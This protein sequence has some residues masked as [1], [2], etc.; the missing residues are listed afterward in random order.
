SPGALPML[1][2]VTNTRRPSGLTA[3]E[4]GASATPRA[5]L[6]RLSHSRVPG[7]A[8][9][10]AVAPA[11]PAPARPSADTA[12]PAVIAASTRPLPLLIGTSPAWIRGGFPVPAG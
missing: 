5:P 4:T 1:N 9:G 11:E 3:I 8:E 12:R 10:C 6:K 7:P 2:P